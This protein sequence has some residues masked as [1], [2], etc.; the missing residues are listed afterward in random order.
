MSGFLVSR[1]LHRLTQKKKAT[2]CTNLHEC[3]LF[4][5]IRVLSEAVAQKY[6]PQ[7][8]SVLIRSICG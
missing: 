3:F 1:R 6:M 7:A 5:C 2:N 8:Y 4:V